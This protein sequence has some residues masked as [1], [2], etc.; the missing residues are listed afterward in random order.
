MTTT[1]YVLHVTSN[2][3]H[4]P[5]QKER[6]KGSVAT[7]QP[8]PGPSKACLV[9]GN[10]QNPTPGPSNPSGEQ[11][12]KTGP[13]VETEKMIACGAGTEHGLVEGTHPPMLH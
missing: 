13:S 1:L 12:K 7:Q 5:A 4:Y 2:K 10:D 6:L 9:K 8:T 3:A 11:Q